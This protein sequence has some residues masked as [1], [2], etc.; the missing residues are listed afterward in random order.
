MD[1]NIDVW[2]WA[3][4]NRIKIWLKPTKKTYSSPYTVN[5]RTKR[6]QIPY[7]QICVSLDGNNKRFDDEYKQNDEELPLIIN[8]L[9][10][11][12]YDSRNS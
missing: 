2:N 8:K 5:G 4:D 9:Y 6:L 7:V 10:K 12:Y 1:F 11:Y 3:M